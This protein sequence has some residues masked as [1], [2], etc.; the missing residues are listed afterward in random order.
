MWVFWHQ[1]IRDIPHHSWNTQCLFLHKGVLHISD[2]HSHRTTPPR[3]PQFRHYFKDYTDVLILLLPHL[4]H[5]ID[6]NLCRSA[7][8][9]FS[10]LCWW[11]NDTVLQMTYLTLK[12]CY[13]T[14]TT[15]QHNWSPHA[16]VFC[17]RR[18][19]IAYHWLFFHLSDWFSF[20]TLLIHLPVV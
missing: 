19:I 9:D 16:P 20:L 7:F 1:P 3:S 4:C 10:A 17:C 15:W 12:W 14:W 13:A 5:K 18:R 11:S 8:L 2:I 6:T